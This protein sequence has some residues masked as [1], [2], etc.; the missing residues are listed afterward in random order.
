MTRQEALEWLCVWLLTY[1]EDW[2]MPLVSDEVTEDTQLY[3]L[4]LDDDDLFDLRDAVEDE[5]GIDL[6]EELF[7]DMTIGEVAALIADKAAGHPAP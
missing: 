3:L 5:H 1:S 4:G 6:S 2:D 7:L